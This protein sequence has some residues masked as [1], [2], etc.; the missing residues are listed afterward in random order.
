MHNWFVDTGSSAYLY[1]SLP[2]VLLNFLLT[3]CH[4]TC[5]RVCVCVTGRE[6]VG[7][8]ESFEL[9]F[10]RSNRFFLDSQLK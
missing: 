10:F 1:R 5:A 3:K 4:A 8:G 7:Q 2:R 6:T 9:A